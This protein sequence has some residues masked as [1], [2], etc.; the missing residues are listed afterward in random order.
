MEL[1]G[2]TPGWRHRASPVWAARHTP[3]VGS[4]V[5]AVVAVRPRRES[6]EW[7]SPP[8][9]C[10]APR[11]PALGCA[12]PAHALALDRGG[13][14]ESRDR[15][16]RLGRDGASVH[17]GM[18]LSPRDRAIVP[19]NPA[20]PPCAAHGLGLPVSRGDQPQSCSLLP[21]L[22]DGCA[23]NVFIIFPFESFYCNVSP[24]VKF[25][26]WKGYTILRFL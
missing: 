15:A 25:V 5:S 24:E 22:V 21:A 2:R 3:C 7:P 6:Q 8:T 11:K 10:P 14:A 20:A 9:G 18:R 12:R 13:V 17:P 1:K 19:W 23:V 26:G 16:A 4:A